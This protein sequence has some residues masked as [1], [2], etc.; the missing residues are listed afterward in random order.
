MMQQYLRIKD[1][2]GDAILLFRLGDFYEMFREDAKIASEV[3]DLTLT[4]K[5]IGGG[6]TVPLAGIPYHA[7]QNYLFKLTRAGYRVAVCEQTEDPKLTKKLV[8]R[9]IVRVV[10][11]G[12]VVESEGIDGSE[13]NYL[14]AVVDGGREG[15]A[16]AL[17]DIS[18]GEFR[19][20]VLPARRASGA[21]EVTDLLAEL[22][23]ASPSEILVSTEFT[24]VREILSPVLRRTGVV[25]TPIA[26]SRFS[27]PADDSGEMEAE[28]F[29]ASEKRLADRAAGGILSYLEETRKGIGDG[30]VDLHYYRP[31]AYLGLDAATERNLELVA[32]LRDGGK[33][34]TLLSVLDQTRTAMGARELRQWILRPLLDLP[35]IVERQDAIATFLLWPTESKEF[36]ERLREIRDLERLLSRVTYRTAGPRDLKALEISLGAIPVVSQIL[37]GLAD[38]AESAREWF[39]PLD[40]IEE[41]RELLARALV[42]EPPAT[43]RD[44]GIFAAGHHA[45]LDELRGISRGGKDWILDLQNRERERTGISTLKISYNKVF[46][47]YI[48][49]TKA[50]EDKVP[51][52]YIRKQTLVGAERYITPELKEYENKVLTAQDRIVEIEREL[53]GQALDQVSQ[54]AERIQSMARRLALLDAIQSLARVAAENSYCRPTLDH[55]DAIEIESGR[56]PTLDRSD[57]VDRFV[58]N[59]AYLDNEAHQVLL[60]T[61]PNMGGKSTFIRQVA[62]LAL[63]AQIG[64]YIPARRA[65]MG[66]V[67][68]IFSRVGA[69]DNLF[70]GQSTFMVEM[71]ETAL[72]LRNATP[73]SLVILDEIGRGTAT[74]D[75]ISLAWAIAE[76]LLH[77]GGQGTKTLFATHY[78]E[79][80]ELAD[81]HDRVRNYHALVAEQDGKVTFLYQIAS[82]TSDHSYGIH[83]AEL[84][85]IPKQVTR[86]ASRILEALES[87]DFHRTRQARDEPGGAIQL[88]LF[89]LFDEPLSEELRQ[90]RPEE[91]TP[92]EALSTLDRLVRR[93]RGDG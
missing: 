69:T 42:E 39:A 36:A 78:H 34:G 74:Y 12:T 40:G 54:F 85:G 83:V 81:K 57:S 61:G 29:S 65:R 20:T 41:V 63:M 62:L 24:T 22:L 21:D 13:N 52:E 88:S 49:I 93:A 55:G 14:A 16:L 71:S 72:I 53:F 58:P 33:K 87:G 18:T 9:E 80:A 79:M 31:S 26:E 90:L 92:M 15:F 73:K 47:Y 1:Q 64:S 8:Q 66:L 89:S 59:D 4:K 68:R 7:L 17:A 25:L 5:H 56:H 48:E 30:L 44:G 77:V 76:Y 70:G 91:M 11:P 86:R 46:G 45:E 51:P 50:H 35:A 28:G 43:S 2:C 82:G 23:K 60:I 6:K 32:N 38:S 67:D 75:G 84:A 19:A 3:L 37:S 10:T 27:T